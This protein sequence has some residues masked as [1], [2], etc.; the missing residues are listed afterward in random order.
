MNFIMCEFQLIS[1]TQFCVWAV[2]NLES[3]KS[4]FQLHEI[5]SFNEKIG[6]SDVMTHFWKWYY[7]YEK[8]KMQHVN[9]FHRCSLWFNVSIGWVYYFIWTWRANGHTV[10]YEKHII[11]YWWNDS[12]TSLSKV[13]MHIDAKLT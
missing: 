11:L 6:K 2:S 13:F 10:H 4:N 5:D 1:F 7:V 3:Q 9:Y 12:L 8:I